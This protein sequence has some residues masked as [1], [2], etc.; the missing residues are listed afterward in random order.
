MKKLKIMEAVLKNKKEILGGFLSIVGTIAA[1]AIANAVFPDEEETEKKDDF[2]F[3]EDPID[4][5]AFDVNETTE[6]E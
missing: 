3:E 4:T 6:N 5:E 2:S 1:T